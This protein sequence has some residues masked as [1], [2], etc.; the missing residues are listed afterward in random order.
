MG[1][2]F[3]IIA[4]FPTV[5]Y[6]FLIFIAVIFWLV[7][8]VGL[9]DMDVLDFGDMST[10]G[11]HVDFHADAGWFAGFLMRFGLD[12]VPLTIVLTIFFFI[13]WMICYFAQLLILDFL[14]LGVL[15]IPVGL[16]VLVVS[17]FPTAYLTGWVCKPLRKVFK[18][19]GEEQNAISAKSLVGQTVI[20]RSSTVTSSFGEAFY[21]DRCGGFCLSIRADE[22]LGLKKGDRVVL[23]EYLDNSA[24]AVVSEDEFKGI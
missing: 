17:I 19:L 16:L 22:L 1:L 14:P 4:S 11:D 5:V 15:R 20:V 9:M 18:K 2:F 13:G 6:T 21:D 10:A 24:Y 23:I 8:A 12:L 7:A 3:T